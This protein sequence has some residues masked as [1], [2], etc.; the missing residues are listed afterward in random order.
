MENA[1]QA[2]YMAFAVFIL[3]IALSLSIYMFSQARETADIVLQSSDITQ[4]LEYEEV[5]AGRDT[6]VVSLETI[7]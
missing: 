5:G 4:F 1:V 7:I 2:L 3:V 6:R